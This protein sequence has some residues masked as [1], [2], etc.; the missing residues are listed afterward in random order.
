MNPVLNETIVCTSTVKNSGSATEMVHIEFSEQGNSPF[1]SSSPQAIDAGTTKTIT[2][3]FKV[4]ESGTITICANLVCDTIPVGT[5]PVANFIAEPTIGTYDAAT[6]EYLAVQFTDL[7]TGNPTSWVWD[8]SDGEGNLPENSM[9]NPAWR[10]WDQGSY[11]ITLTVSNAYGSDAMTKTNYITFGEGEVIPPEETTPVANFVVSPSTG[12][13][14]LTVQFT[15]MSTGA[16]PISYQWDFWNDGTVDSTATNPTNVYPLGTYSV[17]LT[18]TNSYGSHSIIKSGVIVVTDIAPPTSTG[19]V[20][21]NRH[22]DATR[23]PDAWITAAK[24]KTLHFAHTSHG[25]QLLS[26]AEA[27]MVYNPKYKID[28]KEGTDTGLPSSTGALRVHD[29]TTINTYA[30]PDEYWNTSSGIN[31]TKSYANTGLYNYSMFAFCGEIASY[32]AATV[33]K[34][35]NQMDAFE[36]AYPNMRFIYMTGH[37]IDDSAGGYSRSNVIARNQ[38]IRDFCIA[39]NKILFDFEKIGCVAPNGT[40]YQSTAGVG[41]TGADECK[42]TTGGNWCTTWKSANPSHP[43]AQVSNN[44]SDCSHSSGINCACKGGA[45]W[46]LMARLA[47]WDGAVVTSQY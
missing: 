25:S 36:K 14:P 44:V 15:N 5:P 30:T 43:I 33:T 4:T 19:F 45:L 18:A 13:A 12:S 10:F 42:L 6:Q 9:Q 8:M 37:I 20:I 39:N 34:Y 3:S 41:G 38:Q 24:A 26:G 16:L 28:I 29:G 17:K 40:S 1:Y 35:L 31:S 32:S 46:W 2:S 7:S 23:I 22:T 11:T 27:W 47:G 21:D